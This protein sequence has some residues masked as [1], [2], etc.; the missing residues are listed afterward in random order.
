ME[1]ECS[2]SFTTKGDREKTFARSGKEERNVGK[3]DINKDRD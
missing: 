1:R 2:E 3:S